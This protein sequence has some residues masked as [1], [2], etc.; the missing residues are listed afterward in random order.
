MKV[1]FLKNLKKYQEVKWALKKKKLFFKIL[2]HILLL[3]NTLEELNTA[4]HIVFNGKEEKERITPETKI[5]KGTMSLYGEN[6]ENRR[7]FHDLIVKLAGLEIE[8]PVLIENSSTEEESKHILS[9]L[10]SSPKEGMF[11]LKC[12]KKEEGR[13]LEYKAYIYPY[14]YPYFFK[15][16]E[17]AHLS[18][19][20]NETHITKYFYINYIEHLRIF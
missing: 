13:Y 15:T 16:Q 17:E 19:G 6:E 14:S 20:E 18:E 10:A 8:L 11:S 4:Y 7:F 9:S 12:G 5:V 2:Q 3:L 1:L